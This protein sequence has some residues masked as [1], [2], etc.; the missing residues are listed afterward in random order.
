MMGRLKEGILCFFDILA[1]RRRR[2]KSCLR[3]AVMNA[4]VLRGNMKTVLVVKEPTPMFS[5][6]VFIL[7]DNYF[8]NASLSREELMTQARDAADVY[9]GSFHLPRGRKSAIS[10]AAMSAA[11]GSALTILALKLFG[12]A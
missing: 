8:S 4:P 3:E 12:G 1:L 10:L 11:G 6:A 7:R 2:R 9:C 5:Q